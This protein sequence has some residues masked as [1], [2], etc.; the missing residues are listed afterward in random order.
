MA[1]KAILDSIDDLPEELKS[2]Y[3]AQKI[4][5]KDVFVLDVEGIESHPGTKGLKATLDKNKKDLKDTRTKLDEATTKLTGIPDDFT[6]EKWE[7]LKALEDAGDNPDVKK[8]KETY[9]SQL[10]A[11]KANHKNEL[12]RIKTESDAAI[13]AKDI[14]I[15]NVRNQR[16]GDR[17]DVE[18]TQEL[19]KAGIRPELMNAAKALH[20]SKFKHEF[21]EDGTFR[22]F[23]ETDT[24]EQTVSEFVS[25]W[26]NSDEGKAFVAPASGGG[27]SSGNK[28]N[29]SNMGDNPFSKGAWSKTNQAQLFKTDKVKAERLAKAAGFANISVALSSSSAIT[30]KEGA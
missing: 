18:L 10:N 9:D 28:P 29:G 16:A 21:E 30:H 20:I 22:T 7:Q 17:K 8:L 26:I 5:D 25:S 6:A 1:L 11:L 13:A 2:E 23:R 4:N 19:V 14:D 3:K 27:A 12:T 24:G 15:A